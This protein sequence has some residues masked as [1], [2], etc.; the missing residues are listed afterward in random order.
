MSG[1]TSWAEKTH[2]LQILIITLG[3]VVAAILYGVIHD[4]ITA[5]ICVEYFTLGH[6]R[7]IDSD[8]PTSL[9]LFWGI[10]ATWWVGLPLGLGLSVAARAGC[11]PKLTARQLVR[12]VMRL[13]VAMYAVATVAGLI[14]F[15]TAR[16][17]HFVL[18]EPL[19]SRVPADRHVA[20]LTDAWAHSGSY[21]A[22]IVG[23]VVLWVA[24]WRRRAALTPV[25]PP[26]V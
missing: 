26:S 10:I 22:G 8:S 5:R 9:G 16:G 4:Q 2:R 1:P 3:S 23:G 25:A 21:M 14:G 20:F 7:L 13:L 18:L 24:T 12:P 19:A 17:G 6:P 11:R 15:A